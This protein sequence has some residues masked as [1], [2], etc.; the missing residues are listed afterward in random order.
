MRK[1]TLLLIFSLSVIL[2]IVFVFLFSSPL[3]GMWMGYN[4]T[5]EEKTKDKPVKLECVE[6]Q[7]KNETRRLCKIVENV[8]VTPGNMSDGGIVVKKVK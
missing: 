7:Y 3:T 6:I 2:I 8:S 1:L 5:R 4:K